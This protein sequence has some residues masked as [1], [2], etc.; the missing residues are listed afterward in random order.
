MIQY[1]YTLQNNHHNKYSYHPSPYKVT[2][3]FLVMRT[4][5]IYSLGNFQTCTTILLTIV[6]KL[7]ITSP[8]LIYFITES[9][10]LLTPFYYFPTFSVPSP[11]EI[12]ILPSVSMSFVLFVHLLIV[13]LSKIIWYLSFSIWLIS[14]SI[15]PWRSLHV[16]ANGNIS[17]FFMS[18]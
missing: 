16:V 2:I 1:L 13:R 3:C 17:F 8:W 5:K 15:M 18:E 10:S 9:L 14:L 7:Y 6:T 4:F 12:T 11:I